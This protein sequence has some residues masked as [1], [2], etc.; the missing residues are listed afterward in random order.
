MQSKWIALVDAS[1]ARIFA[2]N[3]SELEELYTLNHL[4]SR[5]HAGDL[6]T[7]GNGHVIDKNTKK[8]SLRRTE[9]AVTPEQKEAE[10]FAKEIAVFLREHR[11]AHDFEALML[12]AEPKML[13]NLREKLDQATAN[14]V[15]VTIDK[16][17]TRH[18]SE[19]VLAHLLKDAPANSDFFKIPFRGRF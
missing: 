13:G 6:R 8:A 12:V 19:D 2:L 10:V 4:Q 17:L 18:P 14:T 3:N 1:R 16:N 15:A 9:P 5:L 7:G 11:V